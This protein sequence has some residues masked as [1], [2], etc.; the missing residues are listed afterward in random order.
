M[1]AKGLCYKCKQPFHPMHERPNKSFRVIIVG[2]DEESIAEGDFDFTIMDSIPSDLFQVNEAHFSNIELPFYSVGGISF[3]KMMKLLGQFFNR[4]ITI[5]IDSGASH[6][7]VLETLVAQLQLLVEATPI[8][9]V[10]LGDGH[11]VS[12]SGV[13]RQLPLRLGSVDITVDC[14]VFPL[15]RV[16]IIL[17]V[18]IG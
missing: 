16:E 7:F 13:C 11:Q 17:G 12:T 18:E 2:D 15:G 8:L 4:S 6:N 5:M 10:K 1:R 14:F 3:P 9:M